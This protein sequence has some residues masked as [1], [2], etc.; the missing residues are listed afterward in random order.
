MSKLQ[1]TDTNQRATSLVFPGAE[2][3][4][5]S[6]KIHQS[7]LEILNTCV[8]SPAQEGRFDKYSEDTLK[9]LT[10]KRTIIDSA[11]RLLNLLSTTSLN[12]ES[13][14]IRTWSIVLNSAKSWI[15][16]VNIHTSFIDLNFAAN[17]FLERDYQ[18]FEVL[19]SG[20]EES[21]LRKELYLP[22]K[23]KNKLELI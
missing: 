21:N 22:N 12:Q 5:R 17:G 18:I 15:D 13:R 6:R 1:T 3:P 23:N 4:E 11:Y 7:I 10:G 8:K 14:S 16:Q 20:G 9:L 19:L 2:C